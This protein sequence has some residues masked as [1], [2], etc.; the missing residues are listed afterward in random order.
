MPYRAL[1]HGRVRGAQSAPVNAHDNQVKAIQS[2]KGVGNSGPIRKN[3]NNPRQSTVRTLSRNFLMAANAYGPATFRAADGKD[4]STYSPGQGKG[5]PEATP[6]PSVGSVNRFSR[7]AIARRAV[8][9]GLSSSA[10]CGGNCGCPTNDTLNLVNGKTYTLTIFSDD[11]TVGFVRRSLQQSLVALY[12]GGVY[13]DLCDGMGNIDNHVNLTYEGRTVL[14][15]ERWYTA[16]WTPQIPAPNNNDLVLVLSGTVTQA[17][18][19]TIILNGTSFAP[20]NPGVVSTGSPPAF[21]FGG[22]NV[23]SFT[24]IRYPAAAN[25]IFTVG[26]RMTK[27][28]NLQFA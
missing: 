8:V 12:G 17:D 14:A 6:L 19:P 4:Y 13:T 7:R 18:A 5:F 20:V 23:G 2:Q 15:L 28:F 27:K 26:P 25:A 3:N 1:T 22:V 21:T 16:G 24:L 10:A 9:G 11:N